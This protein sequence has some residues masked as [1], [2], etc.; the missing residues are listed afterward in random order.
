MPCRAAD[1]D[2]DG[3]A[4]R[5]DAMCCGSPCLPTRNR[6]VYRIYEV[7]EKRYPRSDPASAVDVFVIVYYV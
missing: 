7:E 6:E 2:Q 1:E 5:G 4:D 3:R